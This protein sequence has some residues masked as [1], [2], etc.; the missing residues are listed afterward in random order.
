[1]SKSKRFIVVDELERKVL[2][3]FVVEAGSEW[4]LLYGGHMTFEDDELAIGETLP[5]AMSE[6][7][8]LRRAKVN[9]IEHTPKP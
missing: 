1:M 3:A 2:A 8:A 5:T 7:I 4:P 6:S 9:G